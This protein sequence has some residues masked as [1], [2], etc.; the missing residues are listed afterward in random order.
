MQYFDNIDQLLDKYLPQENHDDFIAALVDQANSAIN[1]HYT[2]FKNELNVNRSV[3]PIITIMV[4]TSKNPVLV[5]IQYF[6]S[7]D[8]HE[9]LNKAQIVRILN[10]EVECPIYIKEGA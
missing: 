10:H 1:Q 4:P 6:N 2:E 9:R 5:Q 3:H 7:D 8:E